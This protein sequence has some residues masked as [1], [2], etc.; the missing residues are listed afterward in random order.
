MFASVRICP[1]PGATVK[2]PASAPSRLYSSGS[3][4]ASDAATGCPTGCPLVGGVPPRVSLNV[5]VVRAPSSNTGARFASSPVVAAVACDQMLLPSSLVART[6]TW[7]SVSS[8]RAPMAALVPVTFC[9]LL[10]QDVS[11]VFLCRRS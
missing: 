10:V 8:S 2:R 1:V 4:S 9:G 3:L 11:R 5:R 6:A 7:Y